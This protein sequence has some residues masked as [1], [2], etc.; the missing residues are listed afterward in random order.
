MKNHPE[1]L[2]KRISVVA[3]SLL[4]NGQRGGEER[5]GWGVLSDVVLWGWWV[6]PPP[7]H[8]PSLSNEQ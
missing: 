5:G 8:H 3:F 4:T 7:H 6:S 2:P 1:I